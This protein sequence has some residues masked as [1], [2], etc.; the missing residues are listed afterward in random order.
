MGGGGE[1]SCFPPLEAPAV[2]SVPCWHGL[3][4]LGKL[5]C[6]AG[7]MSLLWDCAC[8]PKHW[9]GREERGERG[10]E[11]DGIVL[12]EGKKGRDGVKRAKRRW[13]RDIWSLVHWQKLQGASRYINLTVS[14]ARLSE[15]R[16]GGV[17]RKGRAKGQ[18]A[19]QRG[20]GSLIKDVVEM[21]EWRV[22]ADQGWVVAAVLI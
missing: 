20:R 10:M 4:K 3:R 18:K 22:E 17:E 9:E 15:R 5:H 11:G 16:R 21:A 7:H 19:E 1:Y 14:N 2:Y 12:M 6:I 8:M 13:R